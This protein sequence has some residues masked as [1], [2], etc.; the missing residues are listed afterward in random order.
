MLFLRYTEMWLFVVHY[1]G[2]PGPEGP[3]GL[4]GNGG[5]KGER[6]NPGQPGQPGL[7]G[8]KGDQGPPGLQVGNGSR[9]LMRKGYGYLNSQYEF[10]TALLFIYLFI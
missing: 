3:R 2:L 9:Y 5:F 10:Q 1:Q 8:L 7:P 4:P 6:G